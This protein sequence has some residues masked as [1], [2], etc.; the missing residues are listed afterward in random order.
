MTLTL[1]QRPNL[2]ARAAGAIYLLVIVFG[3]FSEGFVSGKLIA[4]GDA[5]MTAHNIS[6]SA[7]LWNLSLAGNLLVPII[8]V[9]QL[10]MEYRL[11]RPAGRGL[12]QL[13]VLF[14]LVS[15]A[16]E[17]V[18][19][20]FQLIVLPILGGHGLDGAFT[21]AQ[22]QALAHFALVLHLPD[23]RP[24][25]LRLDLPAPDHRPADA[26]RRRRLSHR[27]LRRPVRPSPVR[28]HQPL[29]P[30]PAADRGVVLLPVASGEGRRR[31][32]VEGAPLIQSSCGRSGSPTALP[33]DR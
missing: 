12:A 28:R 22:L 18:S 29:D 1:E 7:G 15:L 26:T 10:W 30:P 20:L 21:E 5:A 33:M 6:T 14:N 17:A 16:V 31:S 24:A 27:V 3:A 8:A 13:S 11:L 9:P 4:P 23:Q 25:D 32:Q 2:Y 19:K